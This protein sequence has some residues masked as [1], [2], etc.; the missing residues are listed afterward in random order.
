MKLRLRIRHNMLPSDG[1][2]GWRNHEPIVRISMVEAEI[3]KRIGVSPSMYAKQLLNE[4]YGRNAKLKE[5]NH[6]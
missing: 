3:A 6:G 4:H 2:I 5:K 1:T